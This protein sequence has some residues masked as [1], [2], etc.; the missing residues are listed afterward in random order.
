MLPV[1][2]SRNP[3]KHFLMGA[4]WLALA[5]PGGEGSDRCRSGRVPSQERSPA[6][7]QATT[8]LAPGPR[9]DAADCA[10][11]LG[12]R[13]RLGQG[14]GRFQ[15]RGGFPVRSSA[16]SASASS[17]GWRD[18]MARSVGLEPTTS[19][20]AGLRSIRTEL[21]ARKSGASHVA[22]G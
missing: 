8:R 21:R 22:P 5:P 7:L 14:G 1:S 2:N 3:R 9:F 11:Q 13:W 20:S 12:E 19:A 10:R 18:R 6:G 17:G 16:G 4:W 15:S